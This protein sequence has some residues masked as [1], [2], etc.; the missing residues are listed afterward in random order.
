M[1]APTIVARAVRK[2]LP[3]LMPARWRLPLEYYLYRSSA[4]CEPE[5]KWLES[6]CPRRE[7]AIDIGANIGVYS[8]KMAQLFPQVYA[9]EIN[10][11]LIGPLEAYGSKRI[12]VIAKGLSAHAASATLHIPVVNRIP[13]T[14]WASLHVG[15]CPDTNE[16]LD[17]AVEVATLDSYNLRVASLIKIDVEGHELD[18]LAGAERTLAECRPV[19]IA[20]VKDKNRVAVENLL[21]RLNYRQRTLDALVG[22]PGSKENFIFLPQ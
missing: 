22:V 1:F 4:H 9:F 12:S 2:S 7:V 11:D 15:N 19:I 17:K 21:A 16:H 18:V 13:L 5:L 20:E 14:G 6:I 8:Y 10:P 3:S